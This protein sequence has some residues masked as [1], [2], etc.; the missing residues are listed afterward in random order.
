MRRSALGAMSGRKTCPSL[1]GRNDGFGG[2]DSRFRFGFSGTA[3]LRP[4]QPGNVSD[5]L[6][7]SPD[8][9]WSDGLSRSTGLRRNAPVLC[10]RRLSDRVL[11]DRRAS[12]PRHLR[13]QA[14]Q[15]TRQR[16]PDRPKQ[17]V[18]SQTRHTAKPFRPGLRQAC[19]R[20]KGFATGAQANRRREGSCDPGRLD[21]CQGRY[22]EARGGT[23]SRRGDRAA[24][25]GAPM[26]G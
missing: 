7:N 23:W 5:S 4:R 6:V 26:T 9:V 20:V 10:E 11:G 2:R 12:A 13:L 16:F 18:V 17:P 3:R 21:R 14:G 19:C 1:N 22:H 24:D 8:R 15:I 25:Q